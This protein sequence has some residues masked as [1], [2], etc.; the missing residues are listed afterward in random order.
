MSAT[1]SRSGA[2]GAKRRSTRSRGRTACGSATVVRL[3]FPRTAPISPC[4]RTSTLDGAAGNTDAVPVELQPHRPSPVDAVVRGVDPDDLVDQPGVAAIADAGRPGEVG[5]LRRRGDR[6]PALGE[7]GAGRLD[8]P[9][10]TTGVLVAGVD[11]NDVHDQKQ[12]R[13]SS[14]DSSLLTPSR[15]ATFDIAAHSQPWSPRTSATIRTARAFSS[16]GYLH[17]VLTD[18]TPTL[19]RFEVPGHAG[20]RHF[21]GPS[22]AWRQALVVT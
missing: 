15:C 11:P 5:V 19:P 22:V 6:Q 2:S 13:S 3:T 16:S 17:D 20:A 12:R 1:H 4:V 14:A 8:T 7:H 18:M 21:S 10:Q 9:A